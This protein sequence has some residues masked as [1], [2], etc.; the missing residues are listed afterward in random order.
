[1]KV[2]IKDIAAIAGVNHS[3]VSRALNDNHQVSEATKKRIKEIAKSMNFEFNSGARSLK[4]RKTGNIGVVYEAHFDQFGSSLYINQL[5][6]ELRHVLERVDMDAILLEGY[7]PESGGSNID[8]LLRQQKVDAFLIVHD[9]ITKKDYESIINSGLPVVQLHME[10]KFFKNNQLNYF[11]C[12]H[13]LGGR[14]ATEH[15]I[16]NGCKKILTIR[17]NDADSEEYRQRTL[18]Y[19]Q[20]LEANNIEYKEEYVIEIECTYKR[21]YNLF[22]SIPQLI[23]DSDGIFFQTDIQAFGFVNAAAV[24][25]INIPKDLKIVGYDDVSVSESSTPKIS[26][27]HQ[28]RHELAE[29]ASAR[30]MELLNKE[31]C[32]NLVQKIVKPKLVIRE[33]SIIK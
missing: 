33:S 17:P 6:I 1:M 15:L 32:E 27:I 13:I 21:G 14:M 11:I 28:P 30:I 3:T 31:N 9:R 10:P 24:R 18:G 4:S 16:E 20:A 19:R 22:N 2:T 23:D 29:L 8:R 5:F 12:D 7:H 25:G 26:T